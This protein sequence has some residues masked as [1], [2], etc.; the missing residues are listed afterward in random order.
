MDSMEKIKIPIGVSICVDDVG[1]IEGEDQRIFGGPARTAIP[2][3]HH[4]S[5]VLVLQKIAK[6]LGTKILCD[7]VLG[8]WDINNR[9]RRAPYLTWGTGEWDAA[10]KLDMKLAEDY[11]S[12][13]EDSDCLEYG[14]HTPTHGYYE[15]GRQ[16]SGCC[17]YPF[18]RKNAQGVTVREA[19]PD[20]QL[21]E[22]F[23]L[24]YEIYADWGFKKKIE[25]WQTPCGGTGL[26][27]SDYNRRIARMAK[28]YGIG[29][30]EWAGWPK[31]VTVEEDMIFLSAVLGGFV[32]WNACAV[33]PT[34]LA[35][36]FDV[37][38][39]PGIRPNICGHLTNFIQFQVEKN[40]EYADAW[41]D[42]F[43][44][45]TSPFGV[46]IARDNVDSASQAIYAEYSTLDK[47][48]GGYRIDLAGA[49]AVRTDLVKDEFFL[50]LRGGDIP[51][52][53]AGGSLTVHE[54][55][56]DHT[57]YKITRDGAPTVTLAM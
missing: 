36:C 7:L 4:P 42:Y 47:V 16:I 35:N 38:P 41:I 54:T 1:W 30:W 18:V 31:T 5:D 46:M 27:E 15:P 13:L 32:P 33:D 21:E 26:P 53:V 39:R 37:G 20:D 25:A 34:L 14:M 12:A 52:A 57:I 19:L 28:R 56:G 43:R 2:R 51:R 3:R 40:F 22:V 23:S 11:F 6:G 9:L 29:L 8:E 48:D 55:R 24:F 49:D 45:V 50:S 44:R 17:I 10:A